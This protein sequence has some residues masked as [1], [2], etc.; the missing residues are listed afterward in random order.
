MPL[1]NIRFD[2]YRAATREQL[3]GGAFSSAPYLTKRGWAK[4]FR[5]PENL[6]TILITD[7][8]WLCLL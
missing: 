4:G 8:Q 7:I 5:T 1:S 3:E 2:L 6:V